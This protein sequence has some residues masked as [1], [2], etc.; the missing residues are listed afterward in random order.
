MRIWIGGLAALALLLAGCGLHFY[1]KREEPVVTVGGG[2]HPEITWTPATAY[3]L[4]V[5]AGDKDGDGF[6]VLWTAKMPGGFENTLQSPVTYGVTPAG[7]EVRPAAPLEPGKTYTVVVFRK[8][9]KRQGDG[10]TSTGYRYVGT[11]TFVATE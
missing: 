11:A 9:P 3:E 1:D 4:N 5:Y 2:L 7:S 10:F 6:G 8:D